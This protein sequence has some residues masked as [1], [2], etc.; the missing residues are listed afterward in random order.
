MDV[1]LALAEIASIT[2]SNREGRAEP[3]EEIF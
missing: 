1:D 2:H 3:G